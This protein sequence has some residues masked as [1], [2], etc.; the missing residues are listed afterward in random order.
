M[1]VSPVSSPADIKQPAPANLKARA[2]EAFNS[3]SRAQEHP[4]KDASN[5]SVE[6][7]GAINVKT[8]QNIDSTAPSE[9]P[10]QE[11]KEQKPKEDPEQQKRFA[12]LARQERALRAKAQQ[13][14]QALKARE[15][16]LQA[17]E[18]ALKA[19]SSFDPKDYIPR[20]RLKQDALGVIEEEG[21]SYDEVAQ[22]A[23]TRVPVDPRLMSTVQKLEAKIAEL[24]KANENS[25]KTYQEQQQAQ[26]HAAEKQIFN[27]IKNLVKADPTTYEAIAKTGSTRDVL[28]LIT[29]TYDKDGVLLSVEEAAQ[30]VEDYLVEEATKLY[31]INKIKSRMEKTNASSAQSQ[32]SQATKQQQSTMKTLTNATSS[33]RKLSVRE[34]AM[35]AFKGELK[36]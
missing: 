29:R 17:R 10:A 1:K 22:Q 21:I 30:Q 7:L 24:E 15:A 25:Q 9:E 26:R 6:E 33:A 23:M 28:D 13:Q 16:A 18:D 31:Q 34:R 20:A 19:Q 36:P 3:A 35:L 8:E 2:I 4:V 12:Q 14:E 27:D 5:V 32:K 11:V